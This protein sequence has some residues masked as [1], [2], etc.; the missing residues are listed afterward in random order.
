MKQ[1]KLFLKLFALVACL[2]CSTSAMAAVEAYAV[3]KSLNK[4]L[5]F[6]YDD[7]RSS[8]TGLI[9]D[10]NTGENEPGWY[11]DGTNASVRRVVFDPSFAGARPTTTYA[12][13]AYMS[14]LQ[15]VSDANYLNTSSVTNMMAM[16]AGCT[17]LTSIDLTGFNTA[18]VRDMAY[19]FGECSNLTTIAVGSGWT[20]AAVTSSYDM[21][22]DCTS[23]VGGKGTTYNASHTDKAYAHIDGGPS[24]PGYLSG[25]EGYAVI[26]GTTLT[27][28]YDGLR[29]SRPGTSYD[30]NEGEEE[31]GWLV[32]STDDNVS[33]VTQAVFDSSFAGARPTSTVGWFAYMIN[34]PSITGMEYLNTEAVTSMQ[35]MFAITGLTSLDLSS[36]NTANVTNMGTMFTYCSA[37][38]SLDLSSFNTANVTNMADMFRGCEGLTH[39]DLSNFNTSKVTD[40]DYMF[41]WCNNLKTIYVGSGWSTAAVTTSFNMFQDCTSIKGI[42]GTTYNANYV[43]KTRAHIDG[44]TSNPGYLSDATPYAVYTPENT[45]LTFYY[46]KLRYTRPGTSYDLNTGSNPGWYSVNNSVTKVVFDPSFAAARPTSTSSWFNGMTNL[47]SI[48]GLKEYLNT[49]EVTTMSNMFE[50]C[51]SLTSLDVSNFN[52]AQV[53][54]MSGMFENCQSLTSLDVSNFNTAQVTVMSGMFY[55]SQSLTSLDVTSFNTDKVTYMNHM[56][57]NCYSLTSLDLSSFNT[58]KVTSMFAMFPNCRSL[59]SLD[60]SSFNTSNVTYINIMFMGCRQLT[61]IEVGDEWNTAAATSSN[62]MFYNCTSLVGEKGTTYDASHVDKAY[63]HIDGG[64]SNPGYL[65]RP[66]EAYVMFYNGTKLEFYYDRERESR[67]YPTYDLNTGSNNP[68]WFSIRESVKYVEF[69]Q[70][71]AAARPTTTYGW[72]QGMRNLQ[73][74]YSIE[75]LNTEKVTNMSSMFYNCRGLTSLDLS[76]FNTAKVTNMSTMFY[77]CLNLTTLN[78]GSFNTAKV[79]N[80]ASMFYYCPKLET[81]YV[82][83]GWNTTNVNNSTSSRMFL[84]CTSLVGGMGTTYNESN[85]QD[86]TYAHIDGGPSNPGYFTEWH[87]AYV[88]YNPSN[89]TMT[90]YCDDLRASRPGTSFDLNDEYSFPDW[91]YGGLNPSGAVRVVFDPSFAVARPVST[92]GWF[93]GY[94]IASI[95]GMEYLNTSKVT[96]MSYMFYGNTSIS[97]LDLSYFDT[98]KVTSMYS[99]FDGC[100]NLTTIYV[101]DGWSTEAVTSSSSMFQNCTSLVGGMGTTYNSSHVDK[102]YAHIDGGPSNPG[103]FTEKS[104]FIRGDVNGDGN[105]TVSDVTMLISMVLSGNADAAN[106]PAADC[107]QDGNISIADVTALIGRVLRGAW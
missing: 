63:A 97:R 52:T 10:L 85:P 14:Q 5:T 51:C 93:S 89:S 48:T 37:L 28:Y 38:T 53:T 45:T 1:T 49:S 8:R 40:M 59:T 6:Y 81:I 88:V 55:N 74:I 101:G 90:F 70:S 75:Y 27:F 105:V 103:Y 31:P 60:L 26:E 87:E 20:T 32:I 86:K 39:L 58:A 24:N 42:K 94:E 41:L 62:D 46:D 99:M 50:N 11:N 16:F 102:A 54:V 12:W 80:M 92:L 83:D 29:A 82:G 17:S 2:L 56:F 3:Y 21:F 36:F 34:L 107:N 64:T 76:S 79:T 72:F 91:Y 69:D 30:L 78:L 100:S 68:D 13:F 19:M 95:T 104:A 66:R 43:D 73:E 57:S 35:A 65:S 84:S 4:T 33:P 61:T 98:Q 25:A 47:V 18:W 15:A 22:L 44:G 7:Q 96:T 71:F 9:Y 23:L 77:T 67:D 106:Y